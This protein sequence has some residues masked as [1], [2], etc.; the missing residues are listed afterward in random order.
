MPYEFTKNG[1]TATVEVGEGNNQTDSV[2][3]T[4]FAIETGQAVTIRSDGLCYLASAASGSTDLPCTGVASTRICHG[5][6]LTIRRRGDVRD[7]TGIT[8]GLPVYL[9]DTPGAFSNTPGNTEQ[10]CGFSDQ[11]DEAFYFDPDLTVAPS[12]THPS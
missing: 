7:V 9:S 10:H 12:H 3:G 1:E 8:V 5:E 4:A 6:K 2:T 11:C